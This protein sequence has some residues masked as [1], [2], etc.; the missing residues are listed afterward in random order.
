LIDKSLQTEQLHD[1]K[2]T[3][4]AELIN[5]NERLKEIN[6]AISYEKDVLVNAQKTALGLI[7]KLENEK[8][9]LE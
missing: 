2:S 3:E 5:I 1:L 4:L 6:R 7:G 8:T 9:A